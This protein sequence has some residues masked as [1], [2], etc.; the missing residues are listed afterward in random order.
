[1]LGQA[2]NYK[3]QQRERAIYIIVFI[4]LDTLYI[5]PSL[6]FLNL[7]VGFACFKVQLRKEKKKT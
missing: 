5:S 6:C 4:D 3:T 7:K 1:M 2:N